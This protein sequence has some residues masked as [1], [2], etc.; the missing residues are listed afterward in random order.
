MTTALHSG[1]VIINLTLPH[2]PAAMLT[3]VMTLENPI[4]GSSPS[5]GS[6]YTGNAPK[7]EIRLLQ[8]A[9][10]FLNTSKRR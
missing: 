9:K 7:G 3:D 4:N 6:D 5:V 2:P 10:V 8:R 1:E